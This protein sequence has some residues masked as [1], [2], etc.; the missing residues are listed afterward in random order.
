VA[1]FDALRQVSTVVRAF[2]L[3]AG[4]VEATVWR[5][6]RGRWTGSVDLRLP[7]PP[8]GRPTI[9]DLRSFHFAIRPISKVTWAE[10][11]GTL[12]S[13]ER[14]G[15]RRTLRFEAYLGRPLAA[16]LVDD[17]SEAYLGREGSAEEG[18]KPGA[19]DPS[20]DW[21]YSNI[22]TTR[23]ERERFWFLVDKHEREPRKIEIRPHPE[24]DPDF[25]F[26]ELWGLSRR[27]R[28][29]IRRAWQTHTDIDREDRRK[30]KAEPIALT[31]KMA[32]ALLVQVIDSWP[33]PDKR[34]QIFFAVGG[35]QNAKPPRSPITFHSSGGGRTQFRI[36]AELPDT[37]PPSAR[38]EIA[39]LFGNLLHRWEL[40]FTVV[41]HKPDPHGDPRNKHLHAIFYD[42]RC[43]FDREANEW[44]FAI[45]DPSGG[46]HRRDYYPKRQGKVLAVS[47]RPATL[48]RF[49]NERQLPKGCRNFAD[50][51]RKSFAG[52]VN[53]VL[54]K[55]RL[56]G[57]YDPRTYK[58]MGIPLSPMSHYGQGASAFE[59]AGV[60]TKTIVTEAAR[61]WA[62]LE[63]FEAKNRDTA[64]AQA[65]ELHHRLLR[66][67]E[68]EPRRPNREDIIALGSRRRELADALADLRYHYAVFKLLRRQAVSRA[69][70][71][72]RIPRWAKPEEVDAAT[73]RVAAA[74]DHVDA[75][76]EAIR[77]HRE[78]IA[79]LLLK[80]RQWR[81][82]TANLD[83][84]IAACLA[85]KEY[86]PVHAR[87]ERDI[88]DQR[89]ASPSAEVT[90]P[91]A[92]T[93]PVRAPAPA[94]EPKPI[95]PLEAVFARAEREKWW[96]H[97]LSDHFAFD[98]RD[99]EQDQT[100]KKL[101]EDLGIRARAQPRLAAIHA[102]QEQLAATLRT[103]NVIKFD[104]SGLMVESVPE[105]LRPHLQGR[106]TRPELVEIGKQ[107]GRHLYK[108]MIDGLISEIGARQI[109][110]RADPRLHYLSDLDTR[111]L[112][113]AGVSAFCSYTI[114]EAVHEELRTLREAQA[115]EIEAL[116]I[117]IRQD[118]TAVGVDAKLTLDWL[119]ANPEAAGWAREPEI[120]DAV[121]NRAEANLK[122]AAIERE[123][124]AGAQST[125]PLPPRAAPAPIAASAITPASRTTRTASVGGMTAIGDSASP[126][127]AKMSDLL[128]KLVAEMPVTPA[129][130]S[131]P[132]EAAPG[133]AAER[134][135]EPKTPVPEKKLEARLGTL[136]Q[137]GD[138]PEESVAR[139]EAERMGERSA[140][141]EEKTTPSPPSATPAPAP[142]PAPSRREFDRR[143]MLALEKEVRRDDKGKFIV[144]GLTAE[145]YAVLRHPAYL[146]EFRSRLLD[147]WDEIERTVQII[148]KAGA[149]GLLHRPY[150]RDVA[151][152]ALSLP[153]LELV[154]RHRKRR[155]VAEAVERAVP[156]PP[157][158]PEEGVDISVQLAFLKGARGR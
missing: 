92:A 22:A 50:Y 59:K 1:D 128:R 13:Y 108:H 114:R 142:A 137:D 152:G 109:R 122:L 7:S 65:E 52:I 123:R 36:E 146:E 149:Q 34:A 21:A 44:D 68:R 73:E 130:T 112:S 62:E 79:A 70:V 154:R 147:L 18:A 32:G 77:P 94:P 82:E 23:R 30:F 54:R 41:V 131:R 61:R 42:R 40:R 12:R 150:G 47:Q 125:P 121:S 153:E 53:K 31:T 15:R 104:Y 143:A 87:V 9:G 133:V 95:D 119:K 88:D 58:K 11:E 84:Q 132:S 69:E 26:E 46:E 105:P 111:R 99:L 116:G 57:R 5:R 91:P 127:A 136:P 103:S 75:I 45:H 81:R 106:Q 28:K 118:S 76:N 14:A 78:A 157:P 37:L 63:E 6:N 135:V 139:A 155:S 66:A 145:D 113:S 60:P 107:R 4:Q 29:E 16:E 67:A 27:V 126:A 134:A 124:R 55:H 51:L 17:K 39:V 48:A 140:K 117:R 151:F 156:P 72:L 10:V 100:A 96:V 102:V 144:E 3:N 38:R 49:P 115:K 141:R 35:E 43:R 19:A 56:K 25:G 2:T 24:F 97:K 101:L 71:I 80:G 74:R 89:D 86:H 148:E 83:D 64:K 33:G 8:N 129:G 120:E 20:E 138:S 85:D 110:I 93:A 98:Y 158:P 90:S